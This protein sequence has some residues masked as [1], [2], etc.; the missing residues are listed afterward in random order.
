MSEKNYNLIVVSQIIDDEGKASYLERFLN[1]IRRLSN[2]V[3]VIGDGFFFDSISKSREIHIMR[4][5]MSQRKGYPLLGLFIHL[6]NQL[7]I[8]FNISKICKGADFVIFVNMTY[9]LPLIF[10]KAI[11]K[12]IIVIS[13]GL[14]SKSARHFHHRRT[15][16]LAISA[17]FKISESLALQ[18][19]DQI[20]VESKQAVNFLGLNKYVSKISV[21]HLYV[22]ANRFN[23]RKNFKSRK[24][25]I[26]FIGRLSR[27]KGLIEFIEAIPLLL[28]GREDLSF[29]IGGDGPLR[30]EVEKELRKN[31]LYNN[32]VE[33]K[34]WIAHNRLPDYLNEAKLLVL[35]SYSEGLPSIILES[36]A[37]G[38]PV[39]ASPVGAIPELI[40]D[41]EIGFILEDRSPDYIAQKILKIL[42]RSDLEKISSNARR[43][44]ETEYSY[45]SSVRLFKD[46]LKR[47]T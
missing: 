26:A 36:M 12:K 6:L 40:K 17:F 45:D 1:V 47:L 21:F 8:T 25:I 2:D 14:P 5:K 23:I 46:V 34:G 43:I 35:P 18:L 42:S 41:G 7:K 38:T 11:K 37:C 20:L 32:K 29:L 4:V 31:K 16:N 30:Y 27:L 15:V 33:W 9:I 44:I 3:F 28:K 24:N 19:S 13:G 39:L 10:I 22:D